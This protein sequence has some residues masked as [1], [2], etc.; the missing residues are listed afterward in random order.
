MLRDYDDY[1]LTGNSRIRGIRFTNDSE[2]E[3]NCNDVAGYLLAG[4]QV[5][6]SEIDA[7]DWDDQSHTPVP[8]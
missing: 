6:Q 4:C 2:E 5:G 7:G 8:R 3:G 1:E